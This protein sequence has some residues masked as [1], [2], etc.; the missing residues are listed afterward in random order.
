MTGR[1]G[2]GKHILLLK[3]RD[4]I[5]PMLCFIGRVQSNDLRSRRDGIIKK[6]ISSSG[7]ITHHVKPGRRLVFH[8]KGMARRD[9]RKIHLE[10]TELLG[11]KCLGD[12]LIGNL[13][14]YNST[15]KMMHGNGKGPAAHDFV[16]LILPRHHKTVRRLGN[17]I[18]EIGEELR[19]RR[20]A[21]KIIFAV[22]YGINIMNP[23]KSG[24]K[25]FSAGLRSIPVQFAAFGKR[26]DLE[27][28]D[29]IFISVGDP[30]SLGSRRNTDTQLYGLPLGGLQTIHTGTDCKARNQ[31]N[32]KI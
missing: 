26:K 27:R 22:Y 16:T 24:H 15:N 31:T 20:N 25:S 9:I 3:I 21:G 12:E 14:K 1:P 18:L 5:E 29:S 23:G 10:Y 2:I 13:T 32:E 28:R 4:I 7:M 11:G 19:T 17:K 6:S 30:R 8:P